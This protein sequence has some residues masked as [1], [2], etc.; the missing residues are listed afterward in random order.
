MW[1]ILSPKCASSSLAACLLS[2]VQRHTQPCWRNCLA[3]PGG[4]CS[5]GAA[6]GGAAAARHLPAT[7]LP[8]GPGGW[9]PACP[10]ACLPAPSPLTS[11]LLSPY[12]SPRMCCLLPCH[13]F[14]PVGCCRRITGQECGTPGWQAAT[15]CISARKAPPDLFSPGGRLMPCWMA[16]TVKRRRLAAGPSGSA[17]ARSR[18]LHRGKWCSSYINS[19]SNSYNSRLLV[20]QQQTW[21]TARGWR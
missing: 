7:L 2:C 11:L 19:H 16:A 9:V 8:A 18:A 14:V 12:S 13:G 4:A 20:A 6:E 21:H 1:G 10:P 15:W 3:E 5:H 17:S